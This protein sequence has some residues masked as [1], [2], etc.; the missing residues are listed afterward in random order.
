MAA[1]TG[2]RASGHQKTYSST[3][4]SL[5]AIEED[6]A[7]C[8]CYLPRRLTKITS[9]LEVLQVLQVRRELGEDR[10]KR[11]GVERLCSPPGAPLRR[12]GVVGG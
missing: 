11:R 1:T 10:R 8:T 4:A 5:S 9:K 6:F 3:R 12:G 2:L 7:I